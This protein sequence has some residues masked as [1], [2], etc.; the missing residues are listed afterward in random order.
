MSGSDAVRERIIEAATAL[1]AQYEGDTERITS[2]MIAKRAQVGLGLINYHFGSKD[3]LITECVQRII[4]EVVAG[5]HMEKEFSSDRERLTAWAVY[6][7]DFLFEH[8]AI[9]RISILGDFRHYTPSCNSV[10]TQYGLMHALK[11]EV[12]AQDRPMLIF[13]LT[14]AMQAAFLGGETANHVLGY[15]LSKPEQRAACIRRLVG[16]LWEGT[17]M[18]HE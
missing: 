14:A 8:P 2:R 13:A 9:S 7:F 11:K 18:I 6:V 1:I 3:A 10:N 4:S 15:E 17:A 5:F 16:M 12:P